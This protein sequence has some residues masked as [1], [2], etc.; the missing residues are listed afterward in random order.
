MAVEVGL[1]LL[2][3][4]SF[5]RLL[6]VAAFVDHPLR[7][8][9]RAW[10]GAARLLA[11]IKAPLHLTEDSSELIRGRLEPPNLAHHLV[12]ASR[13]HRRVSARVVERGRRNRRWQA[14]RRRRPGHPWPPLRAGLR[15]P[16]LALLEKLGLHLSVGGR[17]AEAGVPLRVLPHALV[18]GPGDHLVA[19]VL[20]NHL[21][22]R[23]IHGL[24]LR[25]VRVGTSGPAA[26]CGD[27][28]LLRLK[29][30]PQL[31]G[32]QLLPRL[33]R[34]C[35]PPQGPVAHQLRLRAI[36]RVRLVAASSRVRVALAVLLLG[37]ALH[38][39]QAVRNH[40]GA[41]RP[42]RLRL[43]GRDGEARRAAEAARS[44][45]GRKAG[46]HGA[47]LWELRWMRKYCM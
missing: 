43:G 34:L 47:D 42:R 17:V 9:R 41:A 45:R 22:A 26:Q 27:P 10:S 13:A 16:D 21:P 23:A 11:A 20:V 2:H 35:A 15:A 37:H 29:A 19:L 24:G 46:V 8:Q 6:H 40:G 4:H 39:G 7:M 38:A 28:V 5:H 44:R 3:S 36:V 25:G 14:P 1:Q 30:L 33:R 31:G 12:E 18:H 32:D